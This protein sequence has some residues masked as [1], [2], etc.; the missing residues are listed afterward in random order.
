M[1]GSETLRRIIQLDKNAK[2]IM[3]TA[4]ETWQV[5]ERCIQDGAMSYLPKPF[6]PEELITTL[7]DPWNYK[8]KHSLTLLTISCN[9]ISS[10]F[11]K[12]FGAP[13]VVK[14]GEIGLTINHPPSN[15]FVT[16][17][18]PRRVV[19]ELQEP[20]KM[21]ISVGANCY[22]SEFVG[23]QNGAIVILIKV[24]D[25]IDLARLSLEY[26]GSNSDSHEVMLELS[27][28][29]NGKILSSIID[30]SHLRL[31]KKPPKKIENL[32][33]ITSDNT[34][35]LKASIEI[36]SK[37]KTIPLQILLFTNIRN[38]FGLSGKF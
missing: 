34:D 28:Q 1:D 29:I 2:V 25:M 38:L 17:H 24:T 36:A 20:I 15:M 33:E 31:E 5:I 26:F 18:L 35:V 9:K 14:L 8:D 6:S 22:G 30:F 3:L 12:I 32:L 13:C 10:L 16:S 37:N 21:E 19:Q 7:N 11:E 4:A 27:N 23:Q